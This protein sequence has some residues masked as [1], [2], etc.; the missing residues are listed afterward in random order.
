MS[1]FKKDTFIGDKAF[2]K[3]AFAIALPV[4]IQ[5]TVTNA[6]NLLD[7]IMVGQVGDLE[8]SA[9]GIINQL[10]VIV[11]LSLF[12]ALSAAGIFASQYAGAKNDEGLRHTLRIKLVAG[13][14]IL[15]ASSLILGLFPDRLAELYIAENTPAAEAEKTIG[16]AV[17]Y[18]R[19]M[20]IGLLPFA[21]TQVYAQSLKEVGETKIPM[22]TSVF[23]IAVNLIFNYLLIFGSLGFPKLGVAGAAIATVISRFAETVLLIAVTH[24][25]KKRFT[26]LNGVYKTLA[27]PKSL[28]V[29]VIKKGFPLLANELLWSTGIA[30]YLQCYSARGLDVV[31]AA[32]ISSAVNNF[33]GVMSIAIGMTVAV[34]VGQKL[35][36]REFEEAKKTSWRLITLGVGICLAIGLILAALSAVIPSFYK[37]SEEVRSLA[38]SFLCVIA[39]S[40]PL[41]TFANGAYFTLRSGGKTMLTFWLDSGFMWAVAVPTAYVLSNYTSLDIVL[42]YLIVQC[43]DL[44]KC[45]I[46]APLIQSGMW[47]SNI[48]EDK[49]EKN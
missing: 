15:I 4:I 36:A 43:L 46:G 31:A 19:I 25:R 10:M 37:T 44:I 9:V 21:L 26:F 35:G 1:L 3:T 38:S 29:D 28:V 30:M 8:Y 18:A 27:V 41:Q 14:L 7:N 11:N 2:Y 48:V 23:A 49:D 45:V 39:V 47:L 17:V 5:Q 32:T 6:V 13:F 40:L 16:F 20:I 34:M 24:K 22:Y 42:V 33:F 12:G